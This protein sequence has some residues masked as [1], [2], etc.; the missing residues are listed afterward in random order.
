M[1]SHKKVVLALG[2]NL[3]DRRENLL[4]AIDEI[5][6]IAQVLSVSNIYET[7]PMGYLEQGNFFNAAI[8]CET[9]LTPLELLDFCKKIEESMGRE[10]SFRNAP[11]P[12]DIDIIFYETVAMQS[13]RLE[14]PHQRWSERD[15]VISPLL[16]IFDDSLY[17]VNFRCDIR[18]ILSVATKKYKPISTLKNA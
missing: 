7:E 2:S 13:E 10:K 14:I 5:S 8:L 1:L 4:R 16:D 9:V 18:S 3:G 11:R 12:I 15:F 17:E 6:S